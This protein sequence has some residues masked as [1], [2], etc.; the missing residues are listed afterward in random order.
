M[1]ETV[2]A[3]ELTNGESCCDVINDDDD[4][5]ISIVTSKDIYKLIASFKEFLEELP[6]LGF[7]SGRIDLDLIK[8]FI[9]P[10]LLTA[11]VDDN[12]GDNNDDDDDDE[13][14]KTGCDRHFMCL[15]TKT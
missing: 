2:K 5:D 8:K 10:Y 6:V 15:K 9:A 7:N 1:L 3:N 13:N 11:H 14:D 4:V 12:D